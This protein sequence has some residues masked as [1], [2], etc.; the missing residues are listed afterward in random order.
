MMPYNERITRA[1]PGCIIVLIDQSG[2]MGGAFGG[3]SRFNKCDVV[4]ESTN[5]LLNT[6]LTDCQRFDQESN[7]SEIRHYFD[8]GVIG[9]GGSTGIGPAFTNQNLKGR[10][11]I[12]I[13]EIADNAGCEERQRSIP[14]GAGGLVHETIQYPFWFKA[15]AEKDTPMCATLQKTREILNNWVSRHSESFPPIVINITDGELTDGSVRDMTNKG[16][17]IKALSTNDGNVLLFNVHISSSNVHGILFPKSP[18]EIPPDEYSQALFEISSPLTDFM[19][20]KAKRTS[21]NFHA[22]TQGCKGCGFNTDF[23]QFVNFLNIGSSTKI[24]GRN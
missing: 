7:K 10:E 8:V 18:H 21:E 2:S 14:D 6:L 4:A 23:E 15:V 11:L 3:D 13:P 12:P 24:E 5:K 16:D 17:E 9:Y 22:L 1:R 19:I 20:D